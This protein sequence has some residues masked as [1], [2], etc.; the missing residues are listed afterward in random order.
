[1][2]KPKEKEQVK[3]EVLVK[4]PY[5]FKENPMFKQPCPERFE[6][7]EVMRNT[8]LGNYILK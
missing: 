2:L 4:L 6:T 3:L 1:M 8:I 5:K 7:I